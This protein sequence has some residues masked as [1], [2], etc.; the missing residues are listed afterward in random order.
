MF[1]TNV[2]HFKN[3]KAGEKKKKYQSKVLRRKSVLVEKCDGI[4]L[5]F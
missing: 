4:F 2:L 3:K 5:F 1:Q